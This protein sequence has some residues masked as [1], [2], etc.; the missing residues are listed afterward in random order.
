MDINIR[1]AI[2]ENFKNSSNEELHQTINEAITSNQEKTL[3]GL[4]VFLE[5][6]WSSSSSEEIWKRFKNLS[7]VPKILRTGVPFS[8]A[9]Q[10]LSKS[11]AGIF[12]FAASPRIISKPNCVTKLPRPDALE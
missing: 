6:V 4:G 1:N 7:V 5:L 10:I 9:Y 11:N 2:I 8:T 3:P 12:F